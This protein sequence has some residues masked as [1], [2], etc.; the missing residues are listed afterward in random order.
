MVGRP[1]VSSFCV[2]T[3]ILK[4]HFDFI[5]IHGLKIVAKLCISVLLWWLMFIDLI[6]SNL[7]DNSIWRVVFTTIRNANLSEGISVKTYLFICTTIKTTWCCLLQ[8]ISYIGGLVNLILLRKYT[9]GKTAWHDT[10]WHQERTHYLQVYVELVYHSE[11]IVCYRLREKNPDFIQ[12]S[13]FAN[14]LHKNLHYINSIMQQY[15]LSI[16]QT[17]AWLFERIK[18]LNIISTRE[19]N[20]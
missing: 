5:F 3:D 11:W 9:M 19:T 20:I 16:M 17:Q 6:R 13:K 2:E 15:T 4:K 7:H 10:K 12:I 18:K 8:K 1:V 14:I